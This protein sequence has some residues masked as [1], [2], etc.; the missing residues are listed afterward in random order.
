MDWVELEFTNNKPDPS[1]IGDADIIIGHSFD[2]E[3][4]AA[5]KSLKAI[6]FGA[7]GYDQI[8]PAAIPQGVVVANAYHHEA[9]IAEWVMAVAVALDHELIQSDRTLSVR[10]GGRSGR[11]G[12]ARFGNSTGVP[13]GS[14]VTV[15]SASGLLD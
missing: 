11:S 4:G 7:A 9:P 10:V 14:L 5:T 13:L 2:S 8:D 3:M 15:L 12:M 6:L 1:L